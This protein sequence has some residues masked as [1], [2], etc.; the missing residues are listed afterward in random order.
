[1]SYYGPKRAVIGPDTHFYGKEEAYKV[2]GERG[3]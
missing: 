2:L 3:R 1:M